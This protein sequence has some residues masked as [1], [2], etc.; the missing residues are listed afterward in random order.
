MVPIPSVIDTRTK[1]AVGGA[2]AMGV[3][4]VI[5]VGGCVGTNLADRDG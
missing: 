1:P 5:G 4:G 2:S 3:V